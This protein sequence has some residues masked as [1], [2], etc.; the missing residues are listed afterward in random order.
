[1]AT[2]KL[3][4][5]RYSFIYLDVTYSVSA[6]TFTLEK[7]VGY[8]TNSSYY[9]GSNYAKNNHYLT[10]PDGQVVNFATTASGG[11]GVNTSGWTWGLT[12]TLSFSVAEG[13]TGA[14]AI[15]DYASSAD[16]VYEAIY[17]STDTITIP[18]S[19]PFNPVPAVYYDKTAYTL[20]DTV[21]INW[22]AADGV[23]PDFYDVYLFRN[24]SYDDYHQYA[25]V[26]NTTFNYTFPITL[27]DKGYSVGDFVYALVRSWRGDAH[28]DSYAGNFVYVIEKPTNFI[29]ISIKGGTFAT[30]PAYISVN[31]GEF[32]KIKKEALKTV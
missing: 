27:A 29:Q 24:N 10:L 26:S 11:Y 17:T 19:L 28:Q 32:K 21:T 6:G 13:K 3:Y 7:V 18:S 4:S 12:G 16:Y 2:I 14:I 15:Q 8:S 1:M 5:N 23:T 22:S 9:G 31:G 30:V 20:N 25:R